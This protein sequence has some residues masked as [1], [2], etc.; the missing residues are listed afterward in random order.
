MTL[1]FRLLITLALAAATLLI[2]RWRVRSINLQNQRLRASL[3]ERTA[4]LKKANTANRLKNEFLANMSHEIRTPIHGL[5]AMVELTLDSEL[6][7]E[8]RENL[9]II[10]ESATSLHSILNDVLDLSKIEA[11]CMELENA[12][13]DLPALLDACVATL[14]LRAKQKGLQL[15]S[16]VSPE[17]PR[18][19]VGDQT[20]LR[21]VL[22]NLLGN[23]IKF[24]QQGEVEV[25]VQSVAEKSRTVEIEFAV[26]DSGIGIPPEAQAKIFGAF[27]QADGSMTRRFGGTGLGLSICSKLVRLMGGQIWL[28]SEPGQGS[29]FHFTAVLEKTEHVDTTSEAPELTLH[30]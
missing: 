21:Q 5:M 17:V 6:T 9:T 29:T 3:E 27:V 16:R 8:Q 15:I 11:N 22:M 1:W 26:R 4:L 18:T 23:A 14:H 7:A 2:Y 12:E 28:E 25:S 19:I 20:R 13:F 24:T 10:S 30:G